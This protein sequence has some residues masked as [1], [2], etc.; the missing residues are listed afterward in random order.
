MRIIFHFSLI[1]TLCIALSACVAL[2]T[3]EVRQDIAALK[4]GQYKLDPSHTSVV[5][6]V[7]H[8]GLSTYVGRFNEFSASLS[9]DQQSLG[10]LSV[11]AN[12]NTASVDV[13]DEELEDTLK[14]SDWFKSADYPIAQFTSTKAT[15]INGA[16]F[17]LE[18]ELT[19]AGKTIPLTL[20]ARFNGGA[21]NML[22]GFHTLG[23]EA[24]GQFSRSALA[25]DKY[26][27]MIGDEI[28]LE[29]HAEFQ[30]RH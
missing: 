30:R 15:N 7:S 2:I 6:K 24:S 14:G 25:L 22:T 26:I 5:F 12:I 1:L 16:D 29:I 10:D 13:N 18:G 21:F 8:M 27:P 20:N 11:Q 23:F 9:F 3:P 17:L 4:P 28:S 19:L